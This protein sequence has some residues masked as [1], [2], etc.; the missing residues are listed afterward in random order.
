MPKNIEMQ[1]LESDGSYEILYPQTISEM[2]IGLLSDETKELM[3]LTSENT[4]DDAFRELYLS[5]V[6][7]GRALIN[8]TVTGNDG[9]PCK[10]VQLA[11]ANFCDGNGNKI[12][13]VTT[14]NEGKISVFVDAI[15]VSVSVSQYANF[16]DWNHTYSVVFG[17]QY[18]ESVI[19]NRRNF[20]K[21]TSSGS[22]K[23]SPE[24]VRV[25]VTCVGGGGRGGNGDS[26][27]TRSAGGG[28]GGGGYCT[29]Q[30]QVS[31]NVETIYSAIIGAGS[32]I[33]S[34]NSRLEQGGSSS[35]LNVNA[36]G[37]Y[38]AKNAYTSLSWQVGGE[39]NG[40]GG[41]GGYSGQGY[42]DRAGQRGGNGTVAGYSSFTE[43]VIYGG[44]GG[45]GSGGGD[46]FGNPLGGAGG[47]YGGKGARYYDGVPGSQGQDG[48][49]GGGGGGG[50]Q[51]NLGDGDGY[52]TAGGRGGSGC[53]AIR[54]YTQETLPL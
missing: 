14:N 5:I 3:G 26:T 54:M 31:F 42:P 17:E 33:V 47:S 19:L 8:F 52:Y 9:T 4:P 40:N 18:E 13:I 24:I 27:V 39:G 35:F 51:S 23:F 15:S 41:S 28:G 16:E 22:C 6:L 37:G 30:E 38:S 7:D 20:L 32:T 50:G 49:G 53:V 2:V 34:T 12:P 10:Q 44:G 25:D 45:G 29:V 11:S 43:T 36:D 1:V 48:F 21:I 46:N